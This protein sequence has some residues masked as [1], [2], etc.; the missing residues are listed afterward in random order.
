MPILPLTLLLALLTL[1]ST[2]PAR[3]L[4]PDPAIDC[5]D[6]GDWNQP[7]APSKVFGNTF[8]VGPAGLSVVLITSPE[9]HILVDGALS[10]SVPI[11]D[12]N[13]RALGYATGDVKLIVNSHA[14][15]DHAAGIAALQRYTGATVAAMADGARAL[16]QGG[17]IESDPQF[18]FG[19]SMSFP[20]VAKVQAMR[21]GETLRVGPL[22]ITG[23]HTPGHTPGGATWTWRSCEG[24]TCKDIVF[25]DSLTAVSAPGFRYT[26]QPGLVDSFRRTISKV[27]SLP[28][29]I[30]IAAHPSFSEGKTCRTLAGEAAARLD[31][32]VAEEQARK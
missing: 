13:I 27:A 6:C 25:A 31:K 12:Q 15:Y 20:P 24:T 9:G 16:A 11:I 26:A 21:D 28:C 19:K 23:H 17:P 22:A 10:Q 32:R 2:Q 30:V 1:V 7:R 3:S 18:G 29:D 5:S 14:H 8:Y 4:V